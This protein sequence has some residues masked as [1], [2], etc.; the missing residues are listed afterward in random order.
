MWSR[1]RALWGAPGLLYRSVQG[2]KAEAFRVSSW[3]QLSRQ[4]AWSLPQ[5]QTSQ[6]LMVSAWNFYLIVQTNTGYLSSEMKFGSHLLSLLHPLC[7]IRRCPKD[8]ITMSR[9]ALKGQDCLTRGRVR[10]LTFWYF[11]APSQCYLSHCDLIIKTCTLSLL[12]WR[13]LPCR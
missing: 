2:C 7:K 11:Q 13:V 12:I 4:V 1:V 5:Q 9:D 3:Q 10:A 6:A 8:S